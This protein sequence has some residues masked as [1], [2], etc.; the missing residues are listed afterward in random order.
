M[1]PRVL[2]TLLVYLVTLS[3]V[4]API[5]GE[6]ATELESRAV[7]SSEPFF[8]LTI[9]KSGTHLMTKLLVMLTHRRPDAL[10]KFVA[11]KGNINAKKM[12]SHILNRWDRGAFP[13][14]H[15][16]HFDG[17]FLAFAE[18]H[19]EYRPI[20]MV[21]DLRDLL[22]SLS[23]HHEHELN[24]ELGGNATVQD[25]LTY[26]LS[27]QSGR[28]DA[29]RR[30]IRAALVLQQDPSFHICRFEDFVGSQ[31]GSSDNVQRREILR[32][33]KHLGIELND[34]QLDFI[35]ANLF[36]NSSGPTSGTFRKGKIGTWKNYFTEEHIEL[37]RQN[38]GDFQAEL[39]YPVP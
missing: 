17:P 31:G 22:V 10:K 5:S 8:L 33:A 12:E 19:P 18:R 11:Q 36:G 21:R 16:R 37:F 23:F 7:N 9:P 35:T 30:S 4:P 20:L 29:I 6:S 25:R 32:L 38:W 1:I 39:G 2:K 13:Y 24:Q 14:Q 26:I 27:L 15:T 3:C 34:S 28:A